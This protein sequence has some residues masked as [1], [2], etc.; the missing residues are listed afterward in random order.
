M[1]ERGSRHKV[2]LSSRPA[3]EVLPRV[4]S[5]L[6]KQFEAHLLLHTLLDALYSAI[7]LPLPTVNLLQL[8]QKHAESLNCQANELQTDQHS[9]STAATQ[10]GGDEEDL[11]CGCIPS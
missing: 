6:V 3:A 9:S 11:H 1:Y 8:G 4:L 5:N 10:H 7:S 2:G